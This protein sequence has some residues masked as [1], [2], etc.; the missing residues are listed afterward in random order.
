M[1]TIAGVIAAS[2]GTLL[3]FLVEQALP[4]IGFLHGARLLLIPMV[5][6]YAAMILPLPAVLAL[7]GF[8][9][10]LTDLANLHVIDGRV[11]IAVGWS[12]VFYVIFGLISHGL[13]NAMLRG[14]WWPF[15]LLSGLGTAALPLLQ[16][17]MISFRREGFVFDSVCVW[18]ILA[19]GM[20]AMLLAPFLHHAVKPFSGL[21]PEEDLLPRDY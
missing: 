11:E 16:L 8:T 15:I 14:H 1:K 13:Q 20:I 9:G 4:S 7:A 19:P 18:R 12:I 21:F 5:F 3:A 2:A 17:V 6:C 10:L